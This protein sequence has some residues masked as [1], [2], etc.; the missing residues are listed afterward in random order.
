MTDIAV[1]L[2]PAVFSILFAL[3]TRELHGYEIM[4][5]VKED[6]QQRISM[7]PGTLYGSIKRMLETG[8]VEEV[9]D[10]ISNPS[11][12]IRRRYYQITQKGKDSLTSELQHYQEVLSVAKKKNLIK[13][14]LFSP[15][16]VI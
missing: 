3:S 5:Q 4:K 10:Q 9:T 1:G 8:L 7:G 16:Y 15:F 13:S 11:G 14:K 6:S 2:T 12:D